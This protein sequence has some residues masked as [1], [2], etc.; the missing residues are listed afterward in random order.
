LAPNQILFRVF[1]S[2]EKIFPFRYPNSLSH[3]HLFF[4]VTTLHTTNQLKI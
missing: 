4:F 1:F 3:L 2:L